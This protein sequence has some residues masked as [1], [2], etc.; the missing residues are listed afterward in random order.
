MGGEIISVFDPITHV[1][2]KLEVENHLVDQRWVFVRRPVIMVGGELTMK[3]L[4]LEFDP[5]SKF[6]V[7]PL[8]MKANNGTFIIDDLGRQAIEPSNLL[9]RW[10]IP[11]GRRLDFLT[12]HT[13]MKFEIPFDEL[14]IFCT[15]ME[16]KQLVD[17]ALLRRIRYKI[18]VGH[19]TE[20]EFNRIFNM[21][22]EKETIPFDQEVFNFLKEHFYRRLGVKP[23]S[24]HPR[25]LLGYIIDG[26]RYHGYTPRLTKEGITNAWNNYFVEA[27][28]GD[29]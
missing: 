18:K 1:P 10:I 4:D 20:A 15:N 21:V 2:V 14:V 13:G 8:Q 23:N 11:L 9:N 28:K 6:Y 7:A 16:P 29:Q 19:P 24:C 27:D 25:D 3:S 26:S 5:I 12:L 17:E 22:C